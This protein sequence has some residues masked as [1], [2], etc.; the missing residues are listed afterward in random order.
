MNTKLLSRRQLRTGV[1]A[2]ESAIGSKFLSWCAKSR[3]EEV[4]KVMGIIKSSFSLIAG[5]V[6][7]IYIAQNYKVPNIK[8][9][10]QNALFKAKD[11]E[12]K[13]RKPPKPG[14]SL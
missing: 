5:T 9:L 7:G 6:C 12:E 14:D 3:S 2:R 1:V 10:I 8:M 13:Y 11:V 4:K